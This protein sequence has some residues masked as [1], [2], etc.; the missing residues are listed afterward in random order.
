MSAF[1]VLTAFR[2]FS[3]SG[4]IGPETV[5]AE[6]SLQAPPR[7]GAPPR[8]RTAAFRAMIFHTMTYYKILYY[9]IL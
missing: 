1:V 7:P 6:P 2:L 5:R 4:S 9:T 8:R 3:G